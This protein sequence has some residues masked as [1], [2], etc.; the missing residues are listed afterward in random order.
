MKIQF[1]SD[2]HLEFTHNSDF[3]EIN[4]LIPTGDILILAGD[5]GYLNHSTYN[6]HPFWDIVSENYEQ[7]LVVPGNH[8]FYGGYDLN[9]LKDGMQVK[10]RENIHWYY[11]KCVTI[12]DIEFILTPLW[13]YIPIACETIINSRLADFRYT[14]YNGNRLTVDVYNKF[15]RQCLSFLTEALYTNRKGKRIIVT[16]HVPSYKC[17]SQ[18]FEGSIFNNAFYS[19]QDNLIELL[20]PDYWIYGHSH[21]NIGEVIIG[22]TIVLSNQLGYIQYKENKSFDRSMHIIL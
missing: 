21:R 9:N 13:S 18:E 5:I 17:M 7:V 19:N 22:K 2:L 3:L 4:P 16:H 6:T 8:E 12:R 14:T 10:I 20:A 15:H 11:N 1:V